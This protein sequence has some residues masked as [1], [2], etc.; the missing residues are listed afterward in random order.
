MGNFLNLMPRQVQCLMDERIHGDRNVGS[1]PVVVR[2]GMILFLFPVPC[3]LFSLSVPLPATRPD[4][5]KDRHREKAEKMSTL[6]ECQ[7]VRPCGELV[8]SWR[9]VAKLRSAVLACLKQRRSAQLPVGRRGTR[10]CQWHAEESAWRLGEVWS[11][12]IQTARPWTTAAARRSVTSSNSAC[13][14]PAQ[15]AR[16]GVE[17]CHAHFKSC[18][19]SWDK[20]RK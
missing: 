13:N 16:R 18:A 2:C 10:Q 19:A 15:T 9:G 3:S 17:G 20:H 1:C 7:T 12:T 8:V 4:M 6:I 11:S 14:F 5:A